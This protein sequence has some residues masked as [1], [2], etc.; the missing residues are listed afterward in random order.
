[1]RS[2]ISVYIGGDPKVAAYHSPARSRS[3][4]SDRL[5]DVPEAVHLSIDDHAD[6]EVKL[7]G[8]PAE[9]RALLVAA[10]AAVDEALA[11]ADGGES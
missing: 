11:G 7:W 9:L 2:L 3:Y 1:M 10:L 8:P 5:L 4:G 6:T